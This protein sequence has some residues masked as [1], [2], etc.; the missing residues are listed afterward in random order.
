MCSSAKNRIRGKLLCLFVVQVM[1][2]ELPEIRCCI[3]CQKREA[4]KSP[5]GDLGVLTIAVLTN[6]KFESTQ[7]S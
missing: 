4:F 1:H 2:S 5:L 3:K 7:K 6:R